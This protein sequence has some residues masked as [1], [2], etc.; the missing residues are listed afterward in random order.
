MA[1]LADKIRDQQENMASVDM[2]E[3]QNL[4][5]S[6]DF[7]LKKLIELEKTFSEEKDLVSQI[8]GKGDVAKRLDKLEKNVAHLLSE[9]QKLKAE[10]SPVSKRIG[11]LSADFE[12][13]TKDIYEIQEKFD[14][15]SVENNENV[16]RINAIATRINDVIKAPQVMFE[17]LEN[18]ITRL[19]D[20]IL[21]IKKSLDIV[22]NIS[23]ELSGIVDTLTDK[24][25]EIDELKRNIVS[26]ENKDSQ[27]DMNIKQIVSR[28]DRLEEKYTRLF[29]IMEANLHLLEKIKSEYIG[30]S[31]DKMDM[32][33]YTVP[34]ADI[35]MPDKEIDKIY[36]E[37]ILLSDKINKT[38]N[39]DE[40]EKTEEV[41]NKSDKAS[42][43][44]SDTDRSDELIFS[45]RVGDLN[46]KLREIKEIG[47]DIKSIVEGD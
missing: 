35:E 30:L 21:E 16:S 23:P 31:Q 39:P 45:K 27:G 18:R 6:L 33:K 15:L 34:K 25:K 32:D 46:K 44:K 5:Y 28:L 40:R 1:N 11:E 13:I 47:Q 43:K 17:S 26:L 2:L 4:K 19:E 29:G 36:G 12:R 7:I 20:D 9:T 22:R 24:M 10:I 3:S 8:R 38:D 42:L 37:N 14:S 41:I